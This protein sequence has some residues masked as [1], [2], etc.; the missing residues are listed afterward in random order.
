VARFQPSLFG[1]GLLVRTW[2]RLGRQG[3]SRAAAFPDQDHAQ[4]IIERLIRRRI[5]RRYELV[6]WT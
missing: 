3:S 2:G 6:A 5:Q 4:L 1:G